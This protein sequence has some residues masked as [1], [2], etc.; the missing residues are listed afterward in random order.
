MPLEH[1]SLV[2]PRDHHRQVRKVNAAFAG[3][4]V[5]RRRV[6]R[7]GRAVHMLID[8]AHVLPGGRRK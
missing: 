5:I 2:A 6:L 1:A 3:G 4:R 8:C 7:D